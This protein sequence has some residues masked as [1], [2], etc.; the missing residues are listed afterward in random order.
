MWPRPSYR[1]YVTLA[2]TRY[3]MVEA[4]ERI[5]ARRGLNKFGKKSHVLP[6]M[7][8]FGQ[9]Q[10]GAFSYQLESEGRRKG[11]II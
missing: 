6:E 1:F 9:Q 11:C 5:F 10:L 7:R 2:A 8:T 3:S 4:G